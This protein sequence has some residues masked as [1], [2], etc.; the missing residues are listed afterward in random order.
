MLRVEL[1][2]LKYFAFLIWNYELKVKKRRNV[3]SWT[4]SKSLGEKG[5]KLWY[6]KYGKWKNQR[7]NFQCP[8]SPMQLN[9]L[10]IEGIRPFAEVKRGLGQNLTSNFYFTCNF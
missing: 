2:P 4:Y 7:S 8:F 3:E 6:K 5:I 10:F 1:I 9:P